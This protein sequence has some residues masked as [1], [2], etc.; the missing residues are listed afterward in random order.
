MNESTERGILYANVSSLS[1]LLERDP[2]YMDKTADVYFRAWNPLE[3]CDSPAEAQFKVEHFDQRLALV[4]TDPDGAV[5]GALH[6]VRVYAPTSSALF[7]IMPT[8]QDAERISMTG[9]SGTGRV[10]VDVCFALSVPERVRVAS[11]TQD[12]GH[13]IAQLLLKSVPREQGVRILAYSKVSELAGG[14]SL[15]SHVR[16]GFTDS[17]RLGPVGL[18]QHMGAVVFAVLDGSRPEDRKGG[19][20]N[21]W[22]LYPSDAAEAALFASIQDV[23]KADPDVAVATTTNDSG[24][25][26][27]VFT[28]IA[29]H[30]NWF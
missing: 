11:F 22:A 29:S 27:H 15:L 1:V 4:A 3:L 26:M 21:V 14:V 2:A 20:G 19:K 18:H 6:R 8:Y 24:Q 9:G 13:T 23:R 7:S 10:S 17:R 16:T 28:D 5:V 25:S 12:R 30:M